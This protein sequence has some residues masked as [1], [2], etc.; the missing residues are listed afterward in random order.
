M[1]ISIVIPAYNES[2]NLPILIEEIIKNLNSKIAFEII[3]VNDNSTDDTLLNLQ[4]IKFENLKLINNLNNIGQSYSTAKGIKAAIY[5]TIVTLDADLQN[6]PSDILKLYNIYTSNNNLKLIG[7]IRKNR[8]DNI[9]KIISSK[10]ANKIRAFILDDK[11]PDTGCSLKIFDKKIF[12]KFPIFDGIHRFLPA[13]FKGYNFSTYF[14]DVNHRA[15]IY[16]K[17]NYGTFGRMFRGIKD[18][19]KV[20]KIIKNFKND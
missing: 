8:K 19:I 4:K 14:V 1:S 18:I 5:N 17:S 2:K 12:L 13:L 7:G 16:G 6:D 11:C 20:R 9:I 3:I 15:R 10:L